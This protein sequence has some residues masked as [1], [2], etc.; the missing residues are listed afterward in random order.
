[1]KVSFPPLDKKLCSLIGLLLSD[2]SVYFDKSKRTYCIQ[3]TNKIVGMRNY[4]KSLVTDLFGDI[5]FSENKCK[6]AVSVRFFSKRIAEFLFSF[7]PTYRTLRFPDG[8][9]PN[10]RIPDEIKYSKAFSSE[11]LKAFA[12]CDGTAHF[13]PK[14]SNRIIEVRCFHPE[15]LRDLFDCFSTLDIRCRTPKNALRITNRIEIG[16]FRDSVGFLEESLICDSNSK[17]FGE[18]KL[19][20]LNRLLS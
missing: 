2:G 12:S 10:C 18:P 11:L 4:F 9:Y 20:I 14:Y 15:L 1:M 8:T 3:F 13:N 19:E 16:K 7:S 6:N 5:K 17:H